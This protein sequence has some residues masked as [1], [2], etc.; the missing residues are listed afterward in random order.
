MAVDLFIPC[1]MT[2]FY[3]ELA[4]HTRNV[5]ERAGVEVFYNDRQTCCGQPAFN[6][7]YWDVS[8]HLAKKFLADCLGERPVVVPSASCA[9]FIRDHYNELLGE[10]AACC[11][12]VFELSDFLVNH[13]QQTNFGAALEATITYHDACSALRDYG[14]KDEPRQLL[15][16][17]KGLKIKEMKE[18]D[19]CCGF[20]GTFMV[21]FK[22]ISVAMAARK[23][24]NALQTGADY[25][26]STE[27]SCLLNLDS[28]INKHKLPIETRHITSILAQH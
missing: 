10:H 13:C 26:V 27:A 28:Y 1:F 7:G 25:I 14:I 22:S 15:R 16:A 9:A 4:H 21:K 2:Q 19:V 5:L 17:V 24:E 3:P 18:S 20:G 11:P 6:S 23:V 8:A 12:P